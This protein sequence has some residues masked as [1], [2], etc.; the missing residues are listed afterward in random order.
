M[1]SAISLLALLLL[2]SCVTVPESID[3][4]SFAARAGVQPSAISIATGCAVAQALPGETRAKFSYAHCAVLSDQ[5][6]VLNG[7]AQKDTERPPLIVRFAEVDGVAFATFGRAKQ[8]QFRIGG[9]L[10]VIELADGVS[11]DAVATR[12]LHT[13]I[14]SA[15][16]KPFEGSYIVYLPD[17]I[18]V[19]IIRGK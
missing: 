19:P 18:Y 9:R 2:T 14:L 10:V 6:I 3:V 8:L 1:R 15:G 4:N 17:T 12:S 7:G 13:S 11:A 5:V 16:A